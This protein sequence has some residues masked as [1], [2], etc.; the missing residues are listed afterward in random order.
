MKRPCGRGLHALAWASILAG[1]LLV[2]CPHVLALNPALDVSQYAHTSWKIRDGFTQGRI[3]SITQTPD[4]YLW[5]GTEFGLFRFDGIRN[6][7]WQPPSDQPL[8]SNRIHS[9]LSTP[10]GTLWIGTSN[11]LASWKDG[12]LTQYRE[13]DGHYIFKVLQ[14]HEGTIWASGLTVSVGKLCAIR[15]GNVQC[16]GGDGTLGRGAF[17]LY[18][19]SHGNLWAGVSAGLWHWKP[20]SPKFYPFAGEADGI[21][22]IGEDFDGTLLIGWNGAIH[23]FADGRTDT[24]QLPDATHRLEFRGILRDRDGGLWIGTQTQ[25]LLHVHEGQTDVFSTSDGLSG[26][27]VLWLFEDHEGSIWIATINGLD[28]FRDFAVATLTVKQGLSSDIVG[29]VF[30]DRD[31]SIWLGTRNGLDRWKNGQITS[32]DKHEGKL[33]GDIPNSLFQ[34]AQGRIWVSTLTAF[35]YLESDRFVSIRDVPGGPVLSIAQDQGGDLWVANEQSGLLQIHQNNVVQRIPWSRLGRKDHASVLAPDS[36]QG[37]LWIGFFLGGVA[38]LV[39]GEIR[40]VYGAEEGLGAGRV[41]DLRIDR[42]GTIWIATEGGLSRLKNGHITTLASKNGLP[43]DT[44]H[45]I[46]EDETHSSWLYTACGLIRIDRSQLEGWLQAVDTDKDARHEIQATVFDGSDGVRILSAGSHFSPQVAKSS[47]GKLWFLPWDG[48]SIIDPRNLRFNKIPP[49]VHIEQ[50]TADHKTYD[51]AVDGSV[52]LQQLVHDIQIDYTALS[53]VAPEKVRFRYKLEGYDRDWQEA[54]NRRQAFYTN[55]RPG[56]YTFRVIACNNNGVWNESGAAMIMII[57]PAFYQTY[58]FL[59]AC[60][61]TAAALIWVLYLRRVRQVAAIYKGRMEERVQERERIARDLHDTFLQSVQGLMLKFDAI[62]QEVPSGETTRQALEQALDR[63]DEVL[64]EGR[65]RLRDLRETSLPVGDLPT[66]FKRVVEETSASHKFTFKTVVEGKVRNLHPMVFE[67]TYYIGRE[68]IL[69]ALMHSEGFHVEAEITYDP[70]QFRLR[71]RDDGRGFDTAI[72]EQGGR[73][74]HWGLPGMQERAQRIGARLELW[75]RSNA[76][77]EVELRIPGAT[78]YGALK[79]K[80]K[81]WWFR[82]LSR[83][84][85]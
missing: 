19:D 51:A 3:T 49:P 77:T 28:R 38:H 26:Q 46:V 68:A 14:D 6:V 65:D 7:P 31:G 42:D 45:W 33:G 43:C 9:L 55:L 24:Y 61:L 23:R 13:L 30:A 62:A 80:R 56:N 82:Q 10:D 70:R 66:A 63:A 25:G 8:P 35:G 85:R 54:G 16:Y 84:D 1:I 44:V 47:D 40:A 37:G 36:I 32:Y 39:N 29:S 17:N 27:D 2:C 67:E 22:A 59:A 21:Q 48:V 58:W 4:G 79:S 57:P 83:I 81:R 18:E 71:I 20:G 73:P 53:L 11:G 75:S 64:A 60:V 5:L 72:I 69:N 76:G 12:R 52:R 34:D 78:A 41:S 15:S 50:I 74:D